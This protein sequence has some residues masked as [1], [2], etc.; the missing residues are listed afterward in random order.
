MSDEEDVI[1]ID[2]QSEDE[3]ID[4]DSS[5]DEKEGGKFKLL[6]QVTE[7]PTLPWYSRCGQ[8]YHYAESP[9]MS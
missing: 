5:E 8:L 1:T 4:I 6:D 2:S 9:C 7:C 3:C